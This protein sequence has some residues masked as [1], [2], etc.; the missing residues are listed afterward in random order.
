[1]HSQHAYTNSIDLASAL[2][3]LGF[4][5]RAQEPVSRVIRPNGTTSDTFFF[6]TQARSDFGELSAME[7][8]KEWGELSVKFKAAQPAAAQVIEYMRAAALNRRE[9]L[10]AV[11]SRVTPTVMHNVGGRVLLVPLNA[12]TETLSAVQKMVKEVGNV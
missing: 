1:M 6:D 9:L 2:I 3:A 10:D 7:V 4:K 5:P 11:K 8:I 12:T